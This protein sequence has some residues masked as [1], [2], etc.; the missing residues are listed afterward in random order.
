METRA[1]ALPAP[2]PERITRELLPSG[3]RLSYRWLR[4]AAYFFVVFCVFWNAFLVFWFAPATAGLDLTKGIDA[5]PGPRLMMLLFPLLH[6]AA[7]IGL[8]YFTAC[9]FVN[10]TVIDVSPREIRVQVGPLPWR[11]NLAVPPAQV[12]QIYREE[13]VRHTKNGRSVS[14]HLSVATKDGRKLKLLSGVPSADQALYLEQE[15]ERHLGIRDQPVTGEMR[16]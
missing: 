2:M 10:R 9:L 11:G 1:G 5:L 8:A 15:I 13:I 14:Y 3:L 6:V 7:G 12:A 4:P 16:K